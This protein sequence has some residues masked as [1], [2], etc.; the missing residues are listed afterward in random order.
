MSVIGRTVG[1]LLSHSLDMLVGG[2]REP[3][4][5]KGE[6]LGTRFCIQP[7]AVLAGSPVFVI[8]VKA[9]YWVDKLVEV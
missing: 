7:W 3:A 5:L 4:Q 1:V 6:R 9:Y 2:D 8:G